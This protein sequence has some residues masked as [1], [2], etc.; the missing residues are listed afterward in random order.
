ME[1]LN[2]NNRS[3]LN[4]III[5]EKSEEVYS[6]TLDKIYYEYNNVIYIF[7]EPYQLIIRKK[8]G[9]DIPFWYCVEDEAYGISVMEDTIE[10]AVKSFY[11]WLDIVWNEYAMEADDKLGKKPKMIKNNLN[12][13]IGEVIKL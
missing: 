7:N 5:I 2:L 13:L 1:N 12:K 3:Y 8:K 11:S 10:E 9:N 4:N 6:A